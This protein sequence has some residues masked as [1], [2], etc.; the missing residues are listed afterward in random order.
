[1]GNY[2]VSIEGCQ[3]AIWRARL[4]TEFT[5]AD[6]NPLVWFVKNMIIGFEGNNFGTYQD[7]YS[8]CQQ[9]AL[10]LLVGEE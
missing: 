5:G 1:M 3:F 10:S 7:A 9:H 8:F 4:R 6:V 2:L